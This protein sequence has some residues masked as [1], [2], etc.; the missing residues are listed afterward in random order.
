MVYLI[1]IFFFIIFYSKKIPVF[2]AILLSLAVFPAIFYIFDLSGI[3]IRYNI[4]LDIVSLVLFSIYLVKRISG[5]IKH[6]L[7]YEREY[8]INLFILFIFYGIFLYLYNNSFILPANDAINKPSF[9][10]LIFDKGGLPETLAPIAGDPFFYPPGYS[11]LLSIFYSFNSSFFVLYIFKHLHIIVISF[12]PAV[13]AYYFMKIYKIDYLKSFLVLISFYYGYFLFDRT[14]VIGP[15]I[16]GKNTIIYCAFLFPAV[17]YIFLYKNKTIVDKIIV[18]LSL[19]GMIL[20]HYSF[21]HMFSLLMFFH[22]IVNIK[23]Q[24]KNIGKYLLLFSGA[25]AIFIPMYLDFKASNTAVGRVEIPL[26][27]AWMKLKHCLLSAGSAF[28]FILTNVKHNWKYKNVF[29][30]IFFLAPLIYSC[31]KTYRF[32]NNKALPQMP[33]SLFKS[34]SVIFLTITGSL[35]IAAGFIPFAG[36]T[37]DYVNWFAYNYFA[38]LASLFFVF[39]CYIII[40]TGNRAVVKIFYTVCF[41]VIPCLMLFYGNDFR[42]IYWNVNAQKISYGELKETQTLLNNLSN[43]SDCNLITE[44]TMFLSHTI[45]KYKPLQYYAVFSDCSFLNGS[46]Y[47]LPLD[48]S[49]DI[50]NLPSEEFFESTT[51]NPIYFIGSKET[52]VDYLKKVNNITAIQLNY[53]IKD[54]C[55]FKIIKT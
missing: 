34:I 17:F 32:R 43:N 31:L 19:L 52:M 35:I 48:Q 10:R 50:N 25:V 18:V 2:H 8:I 49:R 41:I 3:R 9:A 45:L 6:K 1:V 5:S 26:A 30:L 13:W 28:F 7:K 11:I 27:E 37:M 12:T 54:F 53:K 47:T 14:L 4:Y 23:E 51:K 33:D 16:A 36:I 24:K 44:S 40:Q 39:I 55:V 15:A 22:I 29:I 38:L 42:K 46:W 20:I 21:L